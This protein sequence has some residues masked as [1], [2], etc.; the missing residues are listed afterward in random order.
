MAQRR[1]PSRG[2][3]LLEVMVAVGILSMVMLGVA[4]ALKNTGQVAALEATRNEMERSSQRA[5][6]V[7]ALDLRDSAARVATVSADGTSIQFQIPA[8]LNGNGT[9]L[10]S[11]GLVEFGF[12][13]DKGVPRA[14]TITYKFV[15]NVVGGQNELL[16]EAAGR[17]KL[18][19]DADVT[20]KFA[21]GCIVRITQVTGGAAVTGPIISGRWIVQPNGNWGGDI[22]GGGVADPI[23]K[24]DATNGRVLI[25]L[26]AMQID[27]ENHQQVGNFSTSI[28]FRNK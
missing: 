25:N 9:V 21:R 8:D 13:D 23:F 18:N 20:D 10:N 17:R 28:C 7:M 2:F 6:D 26:W 3:T 15:Q 12:L 24:L 16:D 22:N 11:S 5:L 4:L 27:R 19:N 14:G 1:W